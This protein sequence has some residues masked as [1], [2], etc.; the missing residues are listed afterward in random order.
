MKNLEDLFEHQLKDLYSAESQLIE[1]LPKMVKKATDTKLKDAFESHLEET[2]EHKERLVNICKTLDIKPGGETCKA[3]E[4]LI[5][6][7]ESFM[8]ETTNHEVMDAGLIAEAQRVEHYE[9][10][11]YGTAARYAKELGHDDIA[12]ILKKTLDEEYSAD[13]TL[14]Q[15][16][17]GRLNK[18]AI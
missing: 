11:G 7:A 9:I 6:E 3:M 13:E 4:G 15:L 18:K 12:K 17:E 10:S 8:K 5:K 2:K 14:D 16:A 1:A